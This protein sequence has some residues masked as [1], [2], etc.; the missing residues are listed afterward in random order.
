MILGIHTYNKMD[1]FVTSPQSVYVWRPWRW[2]VLLISTQR[3]MQK[4][5]RMATRKASFSY[6]GSLIVRGSTVTYIWY[7]KDVTLGNFPKMSIIL[8][9]QGFQPSNPKPILS[10]HPNP[11]NY[12][13]NEEAWKPE[14]QNHSQRLHLIYQLTVSRDWSDRLHLS[15]I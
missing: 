7:S 8:W 9:V 2:L 1:Q 12:N 13:N 14:Y 15:V 6:K 5:S 3:A 4:Y 11:H 10:S